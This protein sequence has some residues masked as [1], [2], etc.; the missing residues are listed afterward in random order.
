MISNRNPTRAASKIALLYA[1]LSALW[2]LFSDQLLAMTAATR[3][4]YWPWVTIPWEN[5]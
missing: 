3:K 5:P 1:L 4:E 2:I